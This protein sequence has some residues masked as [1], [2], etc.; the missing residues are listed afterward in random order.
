MKRLTILVP[1]LV[2][3]IASVYAQEETQYK[4]TTIAF[5][6]LENL[7]DTINDPDIYLNE[8]F[9]PEGEKNYDTEKYNTKL[10]NL[11]SV[12]EKVGTDLNKQPPVICGISEIENKSVVED[13]VNETC[14]KQ[15]DYGIVHYDSP[16]ERG[17]DVGMIY[18]KAFFEVEH[19]ASYPVKFEEDEDDKTRDQLLVSG[20][21]DGEKMHFIVVHYPSRRGG[22]QA[23]RPKRQ[24]AAD[25]SRH[26]IDSLLD[27]DSNAKIMI[28]GD[29]NDNPDNVSI[30]ENLEAKANKNKLKK[31][32]LYNPMA[33]LYKDGV[34]SGAY[35]DKWYLFDMVIVSQ[36][37]LDPPE[38]TYKFYKGFIYNKPYL[39]QSEGRFKGYPYRSFVGDTWMGG[40]SDH[41]PAYIYLIRPVKK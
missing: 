33:E 29:F 5:Y 39:R 16:D 40:Y 24:A 8:E 20:M 31:G 34:G 4:V 26:I 22:E 23:S 17:V 14:L 32:E 28:M 27:I 18:R 37:L 41:F 13:L 1:F 6:N 12:I 25:V 11:A 21:L 36:G 10:E 30:E 15:Y 19:S 35:R 38:N 9:T 2:A 3:L 7:F